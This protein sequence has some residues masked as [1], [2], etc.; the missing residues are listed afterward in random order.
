MHIAL[1][2]LLIVVLA[3]AG[4]STAQTLSNEPPPAVPD[5]NG[6]WT[7]RIST[8]GGFTG[9]GRGGVTLT[10]QGDLTCLQTSHPC[11]NKLVADRLRPVA[12][13]ISSLDPSKW[14]NATAQENM[15]CNDCY[16][17]TMTLARR[18]G[19]KVTLTT[20][21]WNDVTQRRVPPDVLRLVDMALSGK[22]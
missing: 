20:L 9:R 10:S 19:G 3:S 5:G 7:I 2:T 14:G 17:T 13:L 21:S 22:W 4:F 8:S 1:T 18:E 6:A 11:E 12:Q 15:V 16:T